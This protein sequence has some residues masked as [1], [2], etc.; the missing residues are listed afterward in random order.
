MQDQPRSSFRLA[1]AQ[2]LVEGGKKAENLA[3]AEKR[4]AEAA[5]NGAKVVLLPEA[6]TLGWTH[7]SASTGAEPVPEGEG[8]QRLAQAARTHQVYV[9]GGII[10]RAETD[11]F[12]SA[13]LLGPDGQLLLHHRKINEL[14]IGR[15]YYEPGDRLLVCRTPLG[16]FGVMICADAFAPGQVLSRSLAMMG[17]KI[18]LSPCAWAVP[19]DHDNHREPYGQLWRDHYAPVARDFGIWIAGASNVGVLDQGPWAGRKCIG[20]SL[21]MGPGG[22]EIMMG[23]YGADAETILYANISQ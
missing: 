5:A 21:L 23:P 20:C 14:D 17:A 7:P 11:V 19:A 3:R 2:M 13:V 1:M 9:C 8:C 4:I 10:E 6:L 16:P 18:I 22:K 12:N 15:E